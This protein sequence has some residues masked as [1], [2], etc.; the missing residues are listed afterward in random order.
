MDNLF[1]LPAHPIVIHAAV[2]LLPIAAVGT[3]LVAVWPPLRRRFALLVAICAVAAA[4]TVWMAQES[5]QG[6]ED[7]VKETDLVEEH[8]EEGET[9]LPWALG[10]AGVAV[11]VAG[12]DRYRANRTDGDA[13]R[14][15]AVAIG[16][17]V[18]A[19]IAGAGGTYSVVKVGHSGAKAVWHDTP[20]QR[21]R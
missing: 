13:P 2:V 12:Y 18:L 11:L 6:L 15:N 7:R 20:D 8:T 10:V 4:V 16:L 21:A 19:V 9:V 3:I 5:G 1:G 14:G 17:T